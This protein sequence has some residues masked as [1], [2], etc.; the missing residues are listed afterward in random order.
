MSIECLCV[1]VEY[2]RAL[3]DWTDL[4]PEPLCRKEITNSNLLKTITATIT[5]FANDQPKSM[6][7]KLPDVCVCLHSTL[8]SVW[9]VACGICHVCDMCCMCCSCYSNPKSSGWVNGCM[10]EWASEWA[11][12]RHAPTSH[13]RAE[14]QQVYISL[15][16]LKCDCGFVQVLSAVPASTVHS[17]PTASYFP[18]QSALHIHTH[19][20]TQRGMQAGRVDSATYFGQ[21][22]R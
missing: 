4:L 11:S 13:S 19:T 9:H 22:S 5:W 10:N 15:P 20:H 16:Q 8:A 6:H 18:Q 2:L 7:Y 3:N 21:T 1:C 12:H 14:C 17:P